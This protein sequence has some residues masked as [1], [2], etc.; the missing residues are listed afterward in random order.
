M[1]SPSNEQISLMSSSANGGQTHRNRDSTILVHRAR[2]PRE[3]VETSGSYN[4]PRV[5]ATS[6]NTGEGRLAGASNMGDPGIRE[7]AH[8]GAG[9][10]GGFTAQP[11][12]LANPGQL[13]GPT[14]AT[15]R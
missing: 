9:T 12:S 1:G 7:R 5:G 2:A 14:N 10:V 13:I 8:K 11:T 6:N 15:Q 4:G 3:T